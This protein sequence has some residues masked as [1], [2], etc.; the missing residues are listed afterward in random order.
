MVAPLNYSDLFSNCTGRE[1]SES[2]SEPECASQSDTVA[3]NPY[4]SSCQAQVNTLANQESLDQVHC[5]PYLY[6]PTTKIRY[7]DPAWSTCNVLRYEPV[8]DPPRTLEPASAMAPGPTVDPGQSET[9]A[10]APIA[11]APIASKTDPPTKDDPA[12]DAPA[13]DPPAKDPPSSDPPAKDSSAQDAS[14][15][16][17]PA[18]DLPANDPQAKEDPPTKY[19]PPTKG[20]PANNSQTDPP[21]SDNQQANNPQANDSPASHSTPDS[22]TN[23]NPND[24]SPSENGQTGDPKEH[25]D[26]SVEVLNPGGDPISIIADPVASPSMSDGQG[27]D[28]PLS[29]HPSPTMINNDS[30]MG[31]FHVF[32]DGHII[33]LATSPDVVFVDGQDV[34]RAGPTI[35]VSSTPIALHSNGDLIIGLSTIHTF[36]P[37]PTAPPTE[38]QPLTFTAAGQTGTILSNGAVFAGTTFTVGAKPT[39]VAGTPISLASNG[40]RIGSSVIPFPTPV[41]A[42][43]IAIAGQEL[44]ILTNGDVVVSG[45]T[46]APSTP[47]N[48]EAGAPL[49]SVALGGDVFPISLD[50]AGDEIIVAGTTLHIGQPSVTI[51]GT[52]V[53]LGTSG[54]IVGTSTIPFDRDT[55]SSIDGIGGFIFSGL[56]GGPVAPTATANGPGAVGSNTSTVNGSDVAIFTGEGGRNSIQWGLF[57]L[58]LITVLLTLFM[59]IV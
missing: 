38:V 43:S 14:S 45:H 19:D 6:Y 57:V 26:P 16:G 51:S 42:G 24:G 13:K 22:N 25:S 9:A 49:P 54:L 2:Y 35:H 28:L 46:L 32:V 27:N 8:F 23:P 15:N 30:A 11:N 4:G 52:P 3:G 41:T 18:N 1:P 33:K 37:S 5:Y 20:P 50:R 12:Q 21:Q 17:P 59:G 53:A 40:L 10:P 39:T 29:K 48:I 7:L 44:K 58:A 36:F 56:N 31:S 34:T 47:T 55:S